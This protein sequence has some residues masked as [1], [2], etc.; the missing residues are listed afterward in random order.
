MS[1]KSKKLRSLL[2]G[3]LRW[4]VRE[5]YSNWLVNYFPLTALF[6]GSF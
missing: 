4:T 1:I 2:L 5:F 3:T 6:S